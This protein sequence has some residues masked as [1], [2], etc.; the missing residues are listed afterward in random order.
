MM[1]DGASLRQVPVTGMILFIRGDALTEK[2]MRVS[3]AML[4]S[5]GFNASVCESGLFAPFGNV[6][7]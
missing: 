7:G 3:T 4:R 6:T 2:K 5:R 1:N